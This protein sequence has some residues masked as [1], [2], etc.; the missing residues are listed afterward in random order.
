[1]IQKEK[2][3][4]VKS[5]GNNLHNHVQLISVKYGTN[6]IKAQKCEVIVYSIHD[7]QAFWTSHHFP[8]T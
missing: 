3:L 5:S 6:V 1:V 7:G 4:N 8:C 2:H